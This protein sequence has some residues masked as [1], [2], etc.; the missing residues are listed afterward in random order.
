[1]SS[2]SSWEIS[3]KLLAVISAHWND[4]IKQLVMPQSGFFIVLPSQKES[5][6]TCSNVQWFVQSRYVNRQSNTVFS[7][8]TL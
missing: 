2:L 6:F 7:F 8:A 3:V 1:M 5:S 4:K